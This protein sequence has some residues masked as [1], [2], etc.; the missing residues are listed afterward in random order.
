MPFIT[1]EEIQ[2]E[3]EG[4]R[5]RERE[6][7]VEIQKE[8]EASVSWSQ[9]RRRLLIALL[10]YKVLAGTSSP[11]VFPGMITHSLQ[12]GRAACVLRS[13]H[14]IRTQHLDLGLIWTG[15]AQNSLPEQEEKKNDD[16]MQG[17]R[18]HCPT[19]SPQH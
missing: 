10:P 14:E 5:E 18:S 16:S 12:R 1:V 9:V 7:G 11:S 4:D 3:R 19:L 6:R 8:R 2:K 13:P 15:S 17:L